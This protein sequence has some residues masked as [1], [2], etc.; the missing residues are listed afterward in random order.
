MSASA[1]ILFSTHLAGLRI[2]FDQY[3]YFGVEA[4]WRHLALMTADLARRAIVEPVENRGILIRAK[5]FGKSVLKLLS[6]AEQVNS[7][8]LAIENLS[9]RLPGAN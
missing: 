9:S 2:A 5:L 3:K 1:K 7:G 8:V 6:V 4:A